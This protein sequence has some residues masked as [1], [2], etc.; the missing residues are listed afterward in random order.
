MQVLDKE[1]F[2]LRWS[3][4]ADSDPCLHHL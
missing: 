1:D 3:L 2:T 4:S